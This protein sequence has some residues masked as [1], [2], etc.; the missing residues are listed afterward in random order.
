ME[1]KPLN[2]DSLSISTNEHTLIEEEYHK[3]SPFEKYGFKSQQEF[4]DWNYEDSFNWEP[5]ID[6]NGNYVPPK[7]GADE[8]YVRRSSTLTEILGNNNE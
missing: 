4:D 7:Y 2:E 3:D 5:S 6:E 8:N 1:H